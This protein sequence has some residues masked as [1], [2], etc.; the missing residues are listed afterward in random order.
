MASKVTKLWLVVLLLCSHSVNAVTYVNQIL[1]EGN[2]ETRAS[3][4]RREIFISSGDILDGNKILSSVQ[5]IM[6]LG[7]FRSVDYYLEEAVDVDFQNNT[8]M[9]VIFVVKEK[10][11]LLVIP[12]L[13]T[14][15][16]RVHPGL[17][18]RWDNIGGLNHEFH[19]LLL[20]RGKTSGV[21]QVKKEMSYVDAF[22]AGSDYTFS[23][24]IA[25]DNN[26]TENIL[27]EDENV[28]DRSFSV[29]LS[30]FLDRSHGSRGYFLGYGVRYRFRQFEGVVSGLLLDETDATSLT[31]HF[32]YEDVH[33]YL[34]NRG[35]KEYGYAA[36]FSHHSLGS[37]SEFSIHNL[38]YRSYYRFDSRPDDNLNVQT[39]FSFASN[40][41]L[42]E[43]AFSLGGSDDLRGYDKNRFK[44]NA[45]FLMNIEYLLP[46]EDHPRLRYAFFVD[47]GN[48]YETIHDI[49][50]SPLETAVGFG[51][52]W[53][54]PSF[55]KVDLR[56]DAGYGFADDDYRISA[57]SRHAF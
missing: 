42:D 45:Q 32:G 40:D 30:K 52:R 49:K 55:V 56:I 5:A 3:V 15:D 1:F 38:Y 31:M 29:G 11:Y 7:L 6:D 50:D 39:L 44:G 51:I 14:E 18:L 46:D 26:V 21:R 25:D 24:S 8:Y 19:F 35:G 48:A 20:N 54:I 33:H 10:Y 23:I 36:E 41:V 16:N 4:L 9:N 12:R 43:Y 47:M 34:H 22:V 53:K 27:T 37:Q 28:I 13:K 17:Q 57:S 2:D